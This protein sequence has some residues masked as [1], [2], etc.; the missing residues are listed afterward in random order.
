[1]EQLRICLENSWNDTIRL[2]HGICTGGAGLGKT[3]MCQI[4][5]KEMGVELKE[6][7][8]QNLS[9]PELLRGFLLEAN[10]RDVLLIDEIHELNH[11]VQVG[12]YRAME[13]GMVFL[14]GRNGKKTHSLKLANFT[15]LGATTNVEI[16]LK[17]LR[18]RFRVQYHFELYS[19][20]ELN[21]IQ[22]HRCQQLG[23]W[24]EEEVLSQLSA[25]GR[26]VP[27]IALRLLEATRR[28]CRSE[29]CDMITQQHF[30][31][32]K[33]LEGLDNKGLTINDR[34]YLSILA[35]AIEPVRL[36]IIAT[37]LDVLSP[38][39]IVEMQEKHLIRIGFIMKNDKGRYITEA[40][41]EHISN[42]PVEIPIG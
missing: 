14:T 5:A 17:P 34:R 16:L 9:T 37:R 1:M 21:I 30:E 25:L 7:L 36:N 27:R 24:V 40:G 32:M 35:E 38:K 18:D 42:N 23:W 10:D 13:N 2:P 26:G 33:S 39:S 41:L 11:S 15:L 12:L 31:V 6:Q 28:I 20:P 4:A 22:T 19:E 3:Q 8:A 29:A